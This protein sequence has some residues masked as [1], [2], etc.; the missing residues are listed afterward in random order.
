MSKITNRVASDLYLAGCLKFGRFKTK[1]GA[2]SPYYI[3][4][5]S[6][7]SSP[8]LTCDIAKIAAERIRLIMSSDRI[9]KLAS[10]ELK[11]ALIA[12]SVACRVNLPC[13]VVRKE[14]KAYGITGRIVGASVKQGDSILFFDD[15][16]S[17]GLSK[18]EG[19]KPLQ[20]LGGI[21]KHLLVV[22]DREQGGKENL[23]KLGF[24]L[25]S[26]AKISDIVISLQE[27]KRISKEQTEQVLNYIKTFQC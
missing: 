10:I 23:E 9:D 1:S 17:E 5:A 14:E 11:G 13:I 27:N 21:V 19:I 20:E 16:V 18:V 12:P 25:H 22:V 3:D 15:V 8:K 4:L 26:L 2:I 24:R 7:L 6:L